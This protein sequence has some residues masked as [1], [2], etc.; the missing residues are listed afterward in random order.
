[1]NLRGSQGGKRGDSGNTRRVEAERRQ[2]GND[3][4]IMQPFMKFSN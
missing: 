3:A 2:G 1:M 4:N